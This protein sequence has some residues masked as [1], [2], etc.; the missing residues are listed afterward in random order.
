MRS[1]YL[2]TYDFLPGLWPA[3]S[4]SDVMDALDQYD[5]TAIRTGTDAAKPASSVALGDV[6]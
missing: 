3:F 1:A 5:F 4:S 6:P 2:N